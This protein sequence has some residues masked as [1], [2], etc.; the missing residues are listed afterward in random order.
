MKLFLMR[1]GQAFASSLDPNRGLTP[2]GRAE[3]ARVVRQSSLQQG[4]ID[5]I[6]HSN[7]ARTKETAEMVADQLV[8]ANISAYPQWLAEDADIDTCVSMI[9]AWEDNTML[10][11]HQPFLMQLLNYL[12]P[13]NINSLEP[14]QFSTATMVCFE[15]TGVDAWRL[16]WVVSP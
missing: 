12:Y 1:H 15:K 10:V 16:Q 14:I 8:V 4:D 6:M 7:V 9:S 3:V 2:E 13:E 11:S 5:H